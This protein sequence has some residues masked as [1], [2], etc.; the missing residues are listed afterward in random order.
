MGACSDD[1][2]DDYVF[3]DD[4]DNDGSG[5]GED[6]YDSDKSDVGNSDDELNGDIYDNTDQQPIY[7]S[8]DDE[9]MTNDLAVPDEKVVTEILTMTFK[10]TTRYINH[11]PVYTFTKMERDYNKFEK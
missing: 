1:D 7:I 5:K 8:S 11:G 4:D 10:K 6:G 2:S 3:S 9:L